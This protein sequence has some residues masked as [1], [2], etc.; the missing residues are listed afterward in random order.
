MRAG[1]KC[2]LRLCEVASNSVKQEAY[3]PAADLSVVPPAIRGSTALLADGRSRGTSLATIKVL[4]S[5]IGDEAEASD[6]LMA[7][8]ENALAPLARVVQLR[9]TRRHKIALQ[10][11]LEMLRFCSST[12]LNFFLR[13]MS[14]AT[15]AAAAERHNAL[16]HAGFFSIVRL[17]PS[18][19]ELRNDIPLAQARLLVKMGGMGLTLMM[20]IRPAAVVGTWALCFEPLVRMCPQAARGLNLGG[21]TANLPLR[22]RELVSAHSTLVEAHGGISRRYAGRASGFAS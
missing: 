10:V 21:P 8:V 4:G 14:L 22:L 5:Y 18:A 15:I 9:D 13:A 12:T 3:S 11:Q 17:I 6:R 2:T 7:R 20:Q 1:T 16:I 19:G